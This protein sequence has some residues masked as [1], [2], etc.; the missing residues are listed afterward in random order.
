[1]LLLGVDVP[2]DAVWPLELKRRGHGE[3]AGLDCEDQGLRLL[4]DP[5]NYPEPLLPGAAG[6]EA[7]RQRQPES[8]AA[9]SR[10]QPPR[11]PGIVVNSETFTSVR[12]G[13]GRKD[14]RRRLQLQAGRLVL[15]Q[16]RGREDGEGERRLL[17]VHQLDEL[18]DSAACTGTRS[19][20]RARS[21]GSSAG[22]WTGGQEDAPTGSSP[23]SSWRLVK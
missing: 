16:Q 21:G 15:T 9:V 4:L 1:M 12:P 19:R 11:S 6:G 18:L 8:Q 3:T 13:F 17:A 22:Y 10:S 7:H 20:Q 23:K 14:G 2:E 5:Q